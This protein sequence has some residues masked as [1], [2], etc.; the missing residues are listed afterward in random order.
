MG[1]FSNRMRSVATDLITKLGNP[2][3][4][5]KATQ[6]QYNTITG[7]TGNAEEVIAT[8]S[9]PVK[10]LSEE[11]SQLGINTNLT[12]FSSNKVIVPW[13]GEKITE[14][15]KYNDNNIITVEPIETQ[16][17]VVI[18]TITIGEK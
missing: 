13:V 17:D 7:E 12:G 5:T 2:C 18:Y 16:G 15:W 14:T 6:G 9:A 8:Y 3:T 11:F 10:K 1:T 4:L